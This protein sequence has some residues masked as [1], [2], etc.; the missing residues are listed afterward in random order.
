MVWSR[1]APTFR[2]M[3][4]FFVPP[5][6]THTHTHTLYL[7]TMKIPCIA[8]KQLT[9]F[10]VEFKEDLISLEEIGTI[11]YHLHARG[12]L[13]RDEINK[14]NHLSMLV[15]PAKRFDQV[16]QLLD[17]LDHK[18]NGPFQLIEVLREMSSEHNLIGEIAD[19]LSNEYCTQNRE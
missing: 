18:S 19:I 1:D 9:W 5:P 2:L 15:V 12:V 10:V 6:L 7:C 11:R 3:N 13:T 17:F 8:A 16:Y 14:L 4:N